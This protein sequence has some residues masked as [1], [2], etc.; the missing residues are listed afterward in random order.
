MNVA[1]PDDELVGIVELFGFIAQ[2]CDEQDELI[3]MAL[4]RF[5]GIDVYRAAELGLEA[6]HWAD[7]LARTLGF[8]D[9][10]LEVR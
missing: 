9:A 10:T 6:S 4:A 5:T 1:I 8:A 7:F 3:S 2:L